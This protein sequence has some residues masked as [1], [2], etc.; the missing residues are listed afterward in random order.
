MSFAFGAALAQ[1]FEA[2]LIARAQRNRETLRE[3]VIASVT[4]G[5]ADLIGFTAETDD[6]M[7]EN[8]FCLCHKIKS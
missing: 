4:S 8:D 1:R 5:H 3:E 7:C 2:T 6:V